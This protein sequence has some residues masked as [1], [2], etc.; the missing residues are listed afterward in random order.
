MRLVAAVML[1]TAGASCGAELAVVPVTKPKDPTKPT[2]EGVFYALPRT[3]AK[4]VVKV[5][6]D[7][8]QFA[9]YARFTPIFAPG[10]EPLCGTIAKCREKEQAAWEREEAARKKDPNREKKQLEEVSFSL[11]QGA[12]FSTFGEP[13]PAQVFLVKFTGGGTIDQTLSMTWTE[14]GVL[15]T[16]SATV[17]N[18]T[19]D[20]IM[21]GLKLATSLGT[22]A[23]AGTPTARTVVSPNQCQ[24]N[25]SAD[26]DK[27]IIPILRGSMPNDGTADSTNP[28][29][30]NYCGLPLK[31][32][33]GRE[34][35]NSRDDFVRNKDENDLAA[36]RDAYELRL[37]KLVEQ[38]TALL[39]SSTINVLDPVKYLE[40]I[41]PIIDQQVKDLF[42]GSKSTKTWEI[43]FEV[44]D[45]DPA[46]VTTILG[47][48]ETDGVCPATALYAPDVKP[49]PAGMVTDE[50]KC[51]ASI[52][53]KLAYYPDKTN[54]VFD[55]VKESLPE[56]S[57]DDRSFRYRLPAQVKAVVGKVNK[58][59]NEKLNIADIKETFGA[60]TFS[61]AQLGHIVSLPARRHAKTLQYDL[62]MIEATGALKTFKLGTTGALDTATIDA[63]SAA[64]GTVLDARNA[65]L[66]EAKAEKEKAETKADE[67][68]I[69]T[70]QQTILKLKDEICE[71]QK[72]Y[73][74]ACT[75]QP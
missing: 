17:T 42:V 45:L 5:D 49:A 75:I 24:T 1:A 62:T 50:S 18:R 54:Q 72:K 29:I 13:D 53:V 40:K 65:S 36:A 57:S 14:T 30:G 15:S 39:T 23:A 52:V 7:T 44:R 22:K 70:R 19:T 66:K 55:R 20:I 33:Q 68:T 69:L 38:R 43:P 59:V 48:N 4:V 3:V 34:N 21:S 73:G 12:T 67:L 51:T 71:L 26:N 25:G 27:W 10:A 61:V 63:L 74:L 56:P 11:Q 9:P 60:G 31:D 16:T 2:E 37:A 46:K 47:F 32:R 64:G 35:E 41:E 28:L 6:K 8:K 58:P